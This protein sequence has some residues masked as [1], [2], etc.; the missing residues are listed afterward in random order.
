MTIRI[1]IIAA[2]LLTAA[3]ASP[4]LAS[5]S[6][7]EQFYA[8]SGTYFTYFGNSPANSPRDALAQATGN[9]GQPQFSVEAGRINE[10][11]TL[12]KQ[13]WYSRQSEIY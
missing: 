4:A 8:N 1:K 9:G 12:Q 10:P 13:R 5:D 3:V 11:L 7:S 6:T 2:A